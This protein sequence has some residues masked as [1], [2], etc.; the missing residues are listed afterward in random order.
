MAVDDRIPVYK[1]TLEPVWGLSFLNPWEL[2][3]LKAFAKI[4]GGYHEVTRA[5]PHEFI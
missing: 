3:I 4:K 2:I 1:K 5:R